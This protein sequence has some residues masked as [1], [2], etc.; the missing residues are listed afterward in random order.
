MSEMG[1]FMIYIMVNLVISGAWAVL[2]GLLTVDIFTNTGLRVF[3]Y[4]L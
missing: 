2:Q 3:Y 4:I 1:V